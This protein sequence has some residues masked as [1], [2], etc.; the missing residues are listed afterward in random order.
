MLLKIFIVHLLLKTF[1]GYYIN[2]I[3]YFEKLVYTPSDPF[4]T[5]SHL[6]N[7]MSGQNGQWKLGAGRLD[8]VIWK[9]LHSFPNPAT[10]Q[11]GCLVKMDNGNL[12]QEERERVPAHPRCQSELDMGFSDFG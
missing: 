8:L 7:E 2:G 3:N 5:P 1:M 4:L 9:L 6:S 11:L 10:F 12:E